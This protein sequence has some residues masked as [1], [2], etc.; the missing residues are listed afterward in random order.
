MKVTYRFKD[1]SPATAEDLA[2]AFERRLPLAGFRFVDPGTS[3]DS[4]PL[5]SGA[6]MA[7][8]RTGSQPARA[9]KT[10]EEINEVAA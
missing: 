4:G 8:P 6:T 10:K 3:K 7:R 9:R 1:G 2:Q 5:T